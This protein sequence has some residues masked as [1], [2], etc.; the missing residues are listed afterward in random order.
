MKLYHATKTSNVDSIIENGLLIGNSKDGCIYFGSDIDTA[1]A[2]QF[3]DNCNEFSVIEFDL[4]INKFK[5]KKS[6]DHNEQLFKQ[7]FPHFGKCYYSTLD[8]SSDY[9]I[10]VIDYCNGDWKYRD[11]F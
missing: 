11:I 5:I 6:Y 1:A 3:L 7:N 8:V 4:P 9:L 10:N 2:F